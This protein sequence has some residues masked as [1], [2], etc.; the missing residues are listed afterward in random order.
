VLG[1]DS[2]R[3]RKAKSTLK[4]Q[5]DCHACTVPCVILMCGDLGSIAL[6]LS[7]LV[8]NAENIM[9]EG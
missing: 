9:P 5:N 2:G 3:L 7:V 6:R 4:V 8:C 1:E